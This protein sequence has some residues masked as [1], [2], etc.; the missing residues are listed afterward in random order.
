MARRGDKNV[1]L[2]AFQERSSQ[3]NWLLYFSV[4]RWG[5]NRGPK[6]GWGGDVTT[7]LIQG[8]RVQEARREEGA[9]K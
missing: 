2:T 9:R 4:T 7:M 5:Q 8:N 6:R 1:A 3:K